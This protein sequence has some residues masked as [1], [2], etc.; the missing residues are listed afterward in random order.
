M[1]NIILGIQFMF[2][3]FGATV[4]VPI[5]VTSGVETELAKKGITDFPETY[6]SFSPAIALLAAGIST[7]IFHLITKSKVP[8]FL[9]SSFAFIAPIPLAIVAYGYEN[10]LSG[11]V[12]VGVMYFLFG[13]L[14]KYFG[15]GFIDK[16]FP[17]VVI[18]PVIMVI[19]LSLAPIAVSNAG[20]NW[21]IALITLL[22]AVATVMYGKGM[23]KLIPIFTALV[24]GYLAAYFTGHVD[25]SGIHNAGWLSVPPVVLPAFDW[26]AILYIAPVAIAPIVEHVGNIYAIG[27][28]AGKNFIKEPGL[29]RTLMG[30]G[31]GSF[32]ASFIGGPPST[33]YAEVTGA[34]Q[35]TKVTNPKVLRISAIT[36]IVVSFIGVL[37]ALLTSI[38]KPVLGGVMLLLFGSIAAVGVNTMINAKVNLMN[39]KNQIIASVI[40]VL[41]IGGAHF[42]IGSFQMS[43]IGLCSIVGILLNLILREKKEQN[44]EVTTGDNE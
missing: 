30:D 20:E 5:L 22:T 29:H 9:G 19:G 40:L 27:N 38:P 24:A 13:L 39:T 28:V 12:A 26:Q 43:G 4:L 18:G 6:K 17:P 23:L 11:L 36:A 16:L 15:T 41:G 8:V 10:T 1:K 25:T 34:I 2:V 32:F 31:V 21:G 14:V 33:T 3:A 7:L 42:E 35:L 44:R 37:T